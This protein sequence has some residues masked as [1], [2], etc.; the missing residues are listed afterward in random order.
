MDKIKNACF[1]LVLSLG[2]PPMKPR[3]NRGKDEFSLDKNWSKNLY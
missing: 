2:K 1:T 3:F